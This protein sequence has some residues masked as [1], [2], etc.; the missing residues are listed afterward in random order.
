M[1]TGDATRVTEA[2]TSAARRVPAPGRPATGSSRSFAKP[3][4]SDQVVFAASSSTLA[5]K[6]SA[7]DR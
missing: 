2:S 3:V 7:R 4:D 1:S 6:D 5:S